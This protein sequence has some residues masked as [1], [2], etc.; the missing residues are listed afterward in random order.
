MSD[1]NP[2]ALHDSAALAHHSA[3]HR[4]DPGLAGRVARAVLRHGR[5]VD[6]AL[7]R[8]PVE[9]ARAWRDGL[10]RDVL[11]LVERSESRQ[12][13]STKLVFAT[14]DGE[15]VESVLLR[16]ASGRTSLCLSIQSHC[17]V[18]CAFCASGRA[19]AVPSLELDEVLD[20]VT[21]ARRSLRGEG[22]TL[23]N[24]V[25]MGMGE[26]LLEEELLHAALE[27]LCDPHTFAFP[28]P[29]VLVSTVGLPEAMVRLATARPG[30]RQ[31]LSL[32]SARQEVREQLIPMARRVSLDDL[33][34]AV[35]EVGGDHRRAGLDRVP[36]A[37]GPHRS[38]RGR[39]SPGPVVRGPAGH[40]QPDS[41]QPDRGEG[42]RGLRAHC[43][44]GAR[45]LRGAFPGP[46]DPDHSAA[47]AGRRHFGRLWPA[48]AAPHLS[49][50]GRA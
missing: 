11:T 46:G 39:A 38:A 42:R 21:Q 17:P 14:K 3:A 49:S 22:R 6:E 12:D 10:G 2:I 9:V 44:G 7:A 47:L 37:R 34:Q 33:R 26:P 32:H 18:A 4:V 8:L 48:G 41:L 29:R 16:I 24:L 35:L 23:R 31:A 27:R 5:S 36:L 50:G 45:G 1:S 30:V 19:G 43:E 25:F 15:R 13:G 20:Q 28:E 40:A